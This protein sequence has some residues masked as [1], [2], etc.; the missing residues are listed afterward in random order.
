MVTS[1]VKGGMPVYMKLVDGRWYANIPDPKR[2]GRKIQSS[3]NAYAN[4]KRKAQIELGKV[5]Q[6]IERGID[7]TTARRNMAGKGIGKS[8]RNLR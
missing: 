4:E 3:L 2:P 6:D 8:A 7:P 5:L 1:Q